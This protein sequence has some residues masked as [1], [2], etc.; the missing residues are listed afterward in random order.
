MPTSWENGAPF[1]LVLVPLFSVALG[2]S[3]ALPTRFVLFARL[4]P[5]G[6]AYFPYLCGTIVRGEE[7][8]PRSLFF[9]L[10]ET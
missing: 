9:S 3:L 4:A 6:T 5:E 2:L 8:L 10:D 7:G 1:F